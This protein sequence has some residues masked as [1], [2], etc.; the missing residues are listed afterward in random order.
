MGEPCMLG[1]IS[2]WRNSLRGWGGAAGHLPDRL[3][4]ERRGAL[5]LEAVLQ[6]L[7]TTHL[8]GAAI[9]RHS[10]YEN[11]ARNQMENMFSLPY[12]APSFR[13]S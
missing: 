2:R 12:Q 5:V 10:T 1:A 6:G 8:S 7:S 13:H 4:W 11:I 3:L 9:R